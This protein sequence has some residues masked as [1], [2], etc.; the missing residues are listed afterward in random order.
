MSFSR[1]LSALCLAY[2]LT[3]GLVAAAGVVLLMGDRAVIDP[4]VAAFLDQFE[5]D[6]ATAAFIGLSVVA[7]GITVLLAIRVRNS[8]V[9]SLRKLI[10]ACN[11]A[12]PCDAGDGAG[13][14]AIEAA[15]HQ[16]RALTAAI[17]QLR[18]RERSAD[19]VRAAQRFTHNV[20]QSMFDVLIITD[21]D[22]HIVSVN[23]AAC[24]LL[25]YSELELVGMS[26][27]QLFQDEHYALGV[28]AREM[29]RSNTMRDNEM[30]YRTRSGRRVPALVSASIMRDDAGRPQ[31]IITVGKDI[32]ARKQ[33]E[34]ELLDAKTAAES[35]NRAKSAFVANMSHE[36]R[37]PMTAILGYADLLTRPDLPTA[38]RD[39][40]LQ[41]ICRNGRHLLSIINDILDISKIEAGKM[42]VE[43]INC[44]PAQIVAEVAALMSV[45]AAEGKL[46]FSV[47]YTNAI[48]SVIHSDPTRLRQVIMN[49]LGNAVKFT[50]KGGVRLIVTF[51]EPEPGRASSWTQPVLRFDV[52]DTGVGMTEQQ[53]GT[54]FRPFVQA[55]SSTTRK[56][57][58]TGLGLTI[59]KR[60]A[61]MM[62]GDL[63]V[64]SLPGEGSTFSLIIA[65]GNV[66]GAEMAKYPSF[67]GAPASMNGGNATI[68]PAHGGY[69]AAHVRLAGRVL[70][71]EDGEDNRALACYHLREVGLEVT[72]AETGA[73]AR[74]M[75][76]AA[77]RDGQPFDLIL[78]DMQMPE[79]DGYEATHQLRDMGYRLP[80]VALTAHA[81]GGDRER[82][83]AAGCNDFAIKPFEWETLLEVLKKYTRPAMPVRRAP[84][85]PQSQAQAPASRTS[86]L[87]AL[88]SKPAT[89]K[90]VETFANRLPERCAAIRAAADAVDEALIK[91]LAHQLKGAAG[92]YGFSSVTD[93]AASLEKTLI[94]DAAALDT[95]VRTLIDACDSARQSVTTAQSSPTN[96]G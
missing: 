66:A 12:P 44:M 3:L 41:T 96:A 8:S 60:L 64:R 31:A 83:L 29:L 19:E 48:P 58:G 54:L 10:D 92:G 15:A 52:I 4:R 67:T 59:S 1:R 51:V 56:F 61:T 75:A 39:R 80:I 68:D 21:P 28:G 16:I 84:A 93:A 17:G 18:A 88:L 30:V 89:A 43:R 71:A 49:L 38:E 73:A 79:L 2:V 5:L 45:R 90:L 35:A 22:L 27:E 7:A 20:I 76:L 72:V 50:E 95:A 46:S 63:Q 32:S 40:C 9:R 34:L 87:D 42:T 24:A 23:K 11:E 37:T 82:C 36:I 13:G 26:I 55:D 47:H 14:D 78:M 6:E 53:I 77:Q 65:T 91:R 25:E 94:S 81:M 70:L 33:I 85:V 74:D 57:G 86:H 62:G 69:A